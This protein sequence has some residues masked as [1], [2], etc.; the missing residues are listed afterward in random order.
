[1]ILKGIFPL[2]QLKRILA[3]REIHRNELLENWENASEYKEFKK[4]ILWSSGVE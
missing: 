4:L 1:M 2:K 3:W